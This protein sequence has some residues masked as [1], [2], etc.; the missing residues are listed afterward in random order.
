MAFGNGMGEGDDTEMSEINM[1]PLVDIMLVLLIIFMITV[2]VMTHTVPLELPRA[3]NEPNN[4]LPE[5]AVIAVTA[6]GAVYWNETRL[7][8]KMLQLR[9]EEAAAREPQP[10]LHIRGDR[11]AEYESVIKVMAA[12]QKAG[13]LKLGFITEPGE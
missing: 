2:P 12:A 5:T 9:L 10:E 11:R 7:D 4:I 13:V 1:I 6:D 8:E 3:Q